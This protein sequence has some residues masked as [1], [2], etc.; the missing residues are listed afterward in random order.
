MLI[1]GTRLRKEA[2]EGGC[3][4]SACP[5]TTAL[6]AEQGPIAAFTPLDPE[7]TLMRNI[8]AHNRLSYHQLLKE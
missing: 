8:D 4:S 7:K 5:L 1:P 3:P 6:G 2:G